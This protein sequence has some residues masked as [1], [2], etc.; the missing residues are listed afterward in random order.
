[1]APSS[2]NLLGGKAED[3][4]IADINAAGLP[5]APGPLRG[6]GSTLRAAF[7]YDGFNLYYAIKELGQSHNH[8]KWLN[9]H[10]LSEKL[11]KRDHRLEYVVWCSAL[12]KNNSG[13]LIRHRAYKRALES[14]GVQAVMGHYLPE[15][16]RCYAK[17]RENYWKD[18]EKEGDVNVA[19]RL[20]SDA[21]LDLYDVA[22]LVT[23]DSDQVGTARLF[24]DRFP[25]KTLVTVAPPDRPHSK[26]ILSLANGGHITISVAAVENSLFG[27]PNL[28]KPDGSAAAVRPAEYAPPKGWKPKLYP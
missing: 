17:C 7:F 13:K 10:A 2:N 22:Y 14:V 18:T 3:A 9:L 28:T 8:L 19:I 27:G 25:A 26:E 23:A 4:Y 11:V 20:I 21:H 6:A 15:T 5:S 16:L 24:R 1:M 12:N